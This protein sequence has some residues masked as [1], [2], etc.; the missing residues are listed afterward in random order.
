M[1]VGFKEAEVIGV[2]I[3]FADRTGDAILD[4][5]PTQLIYTIPARSAGIC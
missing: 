3:G 5:N 2:G 4:L 1:T